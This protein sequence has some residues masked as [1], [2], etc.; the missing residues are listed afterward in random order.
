[1]IVFLTPSLGFF[2]TKW[3]MI[4]GQIPARNHVSG[5]KDYL[6]LYNI[7]LNGTLD[8]LGS[9]WENFK[10]K[11]GEATQIPELARAAVPIAILVA[12]VITATFII[13]RIETKK[14]HQIWYSKCN[15]KH[16]LF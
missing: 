12:H 7:Q 11:S 10:T 2:N 5:Y 13:N 9:T 6:Y 14:F 8:T 4:K 1:M 15:N 16:V 3:H